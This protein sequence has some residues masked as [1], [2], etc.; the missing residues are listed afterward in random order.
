MS[1]PAFLIAD[2]AKLQVEQLPATEKRALRAFFK[3]NDAAASKVTENGMR[4]GRV[5]ARRVLWKLGPK[6]K[7]V[8]LSVMDASYAPK[9]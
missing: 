7:P 2:P 8:V 6:G 1:A 4:V 9:T 5:G 3:S